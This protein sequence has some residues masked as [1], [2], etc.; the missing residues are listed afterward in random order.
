MINPVQKIRSF[1]SGLALRFALRELRGGL[2]GFRIFIACIA[3][4]VAAIS[5]VASLSRSLVEGIANESQSILGGDFS[6][7]LVHQEISPEQEEFI[8]NYGKISTM[9]TMRTMARLPDATDAFGE[10]LVEVKAIDEVYPL[11]GEI[12]LK[13][14]VNLA[15]A[16]RKEQGVWGVVVDAI[17]GTQIDVGV[18]DIIS[19][20][21]INVRIAGIIEQEPDLLSQNL[22]IGP[23]LMLS[24]QALRESGLVQP[25]S[26]VEWAYRVRINEDRPATGRE[27]FDSLKAIDEEFPDAG[28][29]IRTRNS[30]APGLV[31]NIRRFAQ[32]LT[33]VGITGL[34]VGGVGVANAVRSFLETKLKVI[35]S[36]K[37]VGASG[38]FVFLVYLFQIL[39]LA[40]IGIIIGVVI[41]AI[42]PVV[43]ATLLASILPIPAQFAIYP[44][45]LSLGIIY[46]FL[47]ALAFAM[48]PLGRAHDIPATALFRDSVRTDRPKPRTRY[49][50]IM[51]TTILALCWIAVSNSRDTILAFSYIA[52]SVAAYA[53]LIGIA[54][55][56]KYVASRFPLLKS[57]SA[58]LAIANIHRPGSLTSSVVLSLGLGLTLL[59]TMTLIDGNIRGYLAGSLAQNAPSFFFIDIQNDELPEFRDYVEGTAPEAT[60]ENAPMLR[61]R[62]IEVKD[63]P[64]YKVRATG[65][66]TWA[67]RGD[68]G[69]T[70]SATLPSNSTLVEGEWWDEDYDGD[71]YLVSMESEV[72]EGIGVKIGDTITVNVLGKRFKA[73]IANLR[74]VEWRSMAINFVLVF[75]P[76][77]FEK[78]P[79]AHL[80]TVT[81]DE[82]ST[83]EQEQS[84]HRAVARQFPT[85]TTVN[86]KNAINQVNHLLSQLAWAIRGVSSITLIASILVL[87]GALAAGHQNR[88]YDSVVLKTL[89]ATRSKLLFA[90]I[91]EYMVLGTA[92]AFFAVIV[93]AVAAWFVIVEIMD[94]EFTF[95]LTTAILAVV[96]ALVLTVGFGLIGTWRVLGEKAAPVLRN[97]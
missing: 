51:I 83:F 48:W 59:V 22:V 12:I 7:T 8:E 28:W 33:L 65:D 21:N 73:T 71:E 27:V 16:L 70:Y 57:T 77:T 39:M 53:I 6:V 60:F 14:E 91:L 40:A 76:N 64:A 46:G 80:A 25:G 69:I 23:R 41:G 5:G 2:K 10:T 31:A 17:L 87:G 37:S 90:Y 35:A 19:I 75:S 74:K 88:V 34:I 32:F 55:V 68:R 13:D 3:L 47:T 11:Y 62:I 79:H 93:G 54:Q 95:Q 82:E 94:G 96:V 66:G 36:F 42:V 58:R 24:E 50:V 30:A 26:L 38:D 72:A 18:G 44:A 61:G 15:T 29:R 81:W 67:L 4:G 97:L 52:G 84:L 56:I 63:E 20:G 78:A 92:T 89:G 43:L 1:K 45:Q 49:I 9:A 86:V 85:V